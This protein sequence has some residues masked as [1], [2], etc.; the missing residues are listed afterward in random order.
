MGSEL[1]GTLSRKYLLVVLI[2][3]LLVCMKGNKKCTRIFWLSLSPLVLVALKESWDSQLTRL[4][5]KSPELLSCEWKGKGKR[6]SCLNEACLTYWGNAGILQSKSP[7]VLRY[8]NNQTWQSTDDVNSENAAASKS[9][10]RRH[11]WAAR[12]MIWQQEQPYSM[13]WCERLCI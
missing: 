12:E 11:L 8:D 10:S 6:N 5:I 9:G 3:W 4:I 1:H 2:N 13:D 7:F